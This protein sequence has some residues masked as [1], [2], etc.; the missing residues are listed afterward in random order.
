MSNTTRNDVKQLAALIEGFA[1]E[2][3][4]AIDNGGDI[5]GPANEL[6]RN[7]QTFVFTLGALYAVEGTNKTVQ[8]TTV[9]LGNPNYHNV[10][11]SRGRF[12]RKV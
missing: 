6:A 9:K 2:F 10:R 12:T 11:D 4:T 1:K 3:Q 7:S 5:L 8:A